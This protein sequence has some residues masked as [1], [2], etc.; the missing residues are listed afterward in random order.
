MTNIEPHMAAAEVKRRA[1]ASK[2]GMI[3]L[4]E[5]DGTH[6]DSLTLLNMF[7]SFQDDYDGEI[8]TIMIDGV[9]YAVSSIKEDNIKVAVL[10]DMTEPSKKEPV[11]KA[12]TTTYVRK[13]L[14][15]YIDWWQEGLK[16][17]GIE[18]RVPDSY[19]KE[20]R[21]DALTKGSIAPPPLNGE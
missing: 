7:T 8:A 4:W 1:K 19:F 17:D 2:G 6:A 14:Q 21:S 10:I 13:S 18:L 20:T 12:A 11:E 3:R 9:R 16:R 15:G 5:L